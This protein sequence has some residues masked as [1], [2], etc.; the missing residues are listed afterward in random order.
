MNKLLQQRIWNSS[1]LVQEEDCTSSTEDTALGV[2]EE[3]VGFTVK[4]AHL[5]PREAEKGMWPENYSL[6]DHA[7]L[8]VVFSAVRM[9]SSPKIL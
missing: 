1:C 6:S 3:A 2:E 4:N 7:R 5:S 9:H 8:T